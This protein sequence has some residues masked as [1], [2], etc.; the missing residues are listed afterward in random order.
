MPNNHK[1]LDGLFSPLTINSLELPNR[2]VMAPMTRERAPDGVPQQENAEYYAR[3]AAGGI[4]LIVSEGTFIDHP[5]AGNRRNVPHLYGEEALKGWRL[6]TEAVH[7]AGGRMFAQ[8]WHVGMIRR[9]VD[10]TYDP[11]VPSIGPSGLGFDMET[12]DYRVLGRAM[13]RGDIADVIAAYAKAAKDARSAGFDGV[14]IHAAH[15]YLIDQFFWAQ[16]NQRDDEY[17]GSAANRGRFAAEIVAAV[18]DAVGSDYPVTMRISRWKI[19]RY[20]ADAFSTAQEMEDILCPLV[21]AGIDAFHCSVRRFWDELI[22][23]GRTMSGWV[24]ELT[25]KPTITVGSVGLDQIFDN[26]TDR[27]GLVSNPVSLD[28]LID[29]FERGEFD[30]VA[31]G[32][33]LLAN[34]EWVNL[35]R[36]GNYEALRPYRSAEHRAILV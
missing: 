9:D 28:T 26:V 25:G 30:M 8:L 27:A 14:E 16:T 4:G 24:R 21:D 3:R 23:P 2:F 31:L 6:V 15:G 1:G 35:V 36:A 10:E 29:H 7:K 20:D 32:R 18:R 34:P 5:V 11:A 33:A 13:D 22:E 19:F 17:G 12:K